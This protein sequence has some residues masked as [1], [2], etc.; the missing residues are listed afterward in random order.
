[1]E[2]RCGSQEW[3]SLLLAVRDYDNRRAWADLLQRY[4]G[5]IRSWCRRTGLGPADEDEITQVVLTKLV[6]I[7]R[8]FDYEPQ[9]GRFRNWLARLVRNTVADARRRAR[10]R[11]GDY[12]SGELKVVEWLEGRAASTNADPEEL[13][14]ELEEQL[15]R[16]HRMRQACEHVRGRV[17][18]RT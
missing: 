10:R 3:A 15:A 2:R 6:I 18:D 13:K 1:M 14:R 8:D 12:G 7:I 17:Q 16:D 9:R 11:P 4:E 5:F